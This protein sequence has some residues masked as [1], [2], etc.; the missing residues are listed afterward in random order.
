MII[1]ENKSYFSH[2]VALLVVHAR[3]RRSGES[4]DTYYNKIFILY[5]IM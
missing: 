3:A 4:T 2:V 5:Y 1:S